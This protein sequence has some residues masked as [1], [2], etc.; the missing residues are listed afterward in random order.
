MTAPALAEQVIRPTRVVPAVLAVAG[1]AWV[2][3][4]ASAWSPWAGAFDHRGITEL[5]EHP[6]RALVYVAG[7]TL[8]V[9]AMMLPT[10]VPMFSMFAIV[11]AARPDRRTL[12]MLLVG[13]Y[14]LVWLAVGVVL[15]VADLGV[16]LLVAQWDWLAAHTWTITS[17]TLALAGGYQLTGLKERCARRCRMPESFLRRNWHGVSGTTET[18]HLAVDHARSCVG[19]CA[20]LM[21]V[22]F[23][24][25]VGNLVLMAGLTALMVAEKTRG[26]GASVRTPVALWLL[27]GALVTAIA[28]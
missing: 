1:V 2:V 9:A 3:L 22:M 13:I 10:S 25:G 19:C 27:C 6:S 16:H 28:G 26:L 17:A 12:A 24:V 18:L 23:A 15:H 7:W 8:M 21:V 11:T 14:L 5:T 20:G 4:A